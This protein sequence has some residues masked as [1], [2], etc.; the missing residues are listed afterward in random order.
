MKSLSIEIWKATQYHHQTNGQVECRIH[1]IKQ[2]MRNYVNKRQNDW[3]QALSKIA[4]AINGTHHVILGMSPY[5]ALYGRAYH[6]LPP[7]IQSATKVPAADEIIDNY[8]AT[9]LEVE[10]AVVN[11]TILEC[12]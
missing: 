6:I 12:R 2:M 5:K 11:I 8:E 7:L 10:Q 1:T 9:R 3:C 4:A